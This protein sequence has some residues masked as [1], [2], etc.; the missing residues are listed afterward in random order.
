MAYEAYDLDGQPGYG[1]APAPRTSPFSRESPTHVALV[2]AF[3]DRLIRWLKDPN[4]QA[5]FEKLSSYQPDPY[6]QW[7]PMRKMSPEKLRTLLLTAR[8]SA[9]AMGLPGAD[10]Q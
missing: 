1:F 9:S 10:G 7:G 4:L 2:Q 6:A 3:T 5:A 8:G